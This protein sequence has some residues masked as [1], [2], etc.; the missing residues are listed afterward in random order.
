MIFNGVNLLLRVNL[1]LLSLF[2][3][4]RMLVDLLDLLL[5]LFKGTFKEDKPSLLNNDVLFILSFREL[6]ISLN[7][8]FINS[9]ILNV[10]FEFT[11]FN[12]IISL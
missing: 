7:P 3:V 8:S 5:R 12:S 6:I 11:I 10:L 9:H 1:L 4:C 2:L